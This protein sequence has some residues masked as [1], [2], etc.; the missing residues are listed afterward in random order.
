MKTKFDCVAMK[1]QAA[2]KI[3]AKISNL[4]LVE[5]L[6]FWQERASALRKQKEASLKKQNLLEANA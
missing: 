3:Q 4:T 1:H 2:E 6:K 5:E